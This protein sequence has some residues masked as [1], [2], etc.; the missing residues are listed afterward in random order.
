MSTFNFVDFLILGVM[1]LSVLFG[2][3]SGFIRS[4]IS[5]LVWIAAFGVALIW[6]PEVA[7]TFAGWVSD[8][9]IQLWLAY[10]S[11]FVSVFIV[12]AIIRMFL[13]VALMATLIGPTDRFIGAGFGLLRGIVVVT[14]SLWFATLVGVTQTPSMQQ[15][16][17]VKVFAPLVTGVALLFPHASEVIA[18][19]AAKVSDSIQNGKSTVQGLGAPGGSV[20][21][22][23]SGSGGGFNG[24]GVISKT[25]QFAGQAVQQVKANLSH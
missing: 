14:F 21:G 6:G 12:G 24:S 2:F 13:R 25:Q 3:I 20:P 8:P 11:I 16:I 4:V 5:L 7:D 15:S 10:G 23:G 1:G 18:S 19:S 9:S 22:M 17:L